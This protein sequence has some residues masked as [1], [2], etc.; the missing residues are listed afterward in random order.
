MQY[1]MLNILRQRRLFDVSKRSDLL[2]FKYF[3]ENNKW[4][5]GCPFYVEYPWE[6]IPSMCK[7]KFAAHMLSKL[8]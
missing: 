1:S 2:E 8:K 5:E 3:V 6:D 7:D 4:R